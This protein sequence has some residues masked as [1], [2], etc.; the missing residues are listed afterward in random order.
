M[1]ENEE[2]Q[3]WFVLLNGKRYGPYTLPALVKG[4]EKGVIG[5]SAGVWRPGWDE[6]RTASDIEELFA[7]EPPPVEEFEEQ[8]ELEERAETPATSPEQLEEPQEEKQ[9]PEQAEPAEVAAED[10]GGSED[11]VPTELV[12]TD[13]ADA[14]ST[15]PLST[16]PEPDA[17]DL[18]LAEAKEANAE[19]DEA[20]ETDTG[21]PREVRESVRRNRFRDGP[22]LFGRGFARS[23]PV[24]L[25]PIKPDPPR[26]APPK[27]DRARPE[28]GKLDPP[29]LD[30]PKLDFGAT[31]RREATPDPGARDPGA[32]N[33]LSRAI[34]NELGAPDIG[35]R[36]PPLADA[37][38]RVRL[39]TMLAS[40]D[41]AA[42]R[43]ED[44]EELEAGPR[45]DPK[46]GEPEDPAKPTVA[47][48]RLSDVSSAARAR[49][50]DV[51]ADIVTAR[52]AA[53]FPAGVPPVLAPEPVPE[54]EGARRGGG[55]MAVILSVVATLIVV[56]AAALGA[57]ALGLMRVEFLPKQGGRGAAALQSLPVDSSAVRPHATL[58]GLPDIVANMPAVIALKMAD[59]EAY[60]RFV[61][62]F[63]G[64]YHDNEP[65][66]VILTQAR[67]AVRKSIKHMLANA[68][69]E[70]LL[71][72]TEVNLGYMRGLAQSNAGSC[73][74]L[75]DESKG[76]V[77]DA[78]LARDFPPLFE[79][80]MAVLERVI[81]NSGSKQT[82]PTEAE[83]RPYLEAV[84]ADLKNKPVQMQLLG[85]D[86]LTEAE[87]APYCDLVIA[88]YEGVRALP[89]ND[90]VKLLRNLY[91]A[92]A[93]DPDKS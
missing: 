58:D 89:F 20:K 74:A 5:R 13:S 31:T 1:P 33:L 62:R 21:S 41:V 18:E 32:R 42:P 69:N 64:V 25:E 19:A 70:S 82:A 46:K 87:Y 45:A 50:A 55:L 17:A 10:R 88:F 73:V 29:K 37:A 9:E 23:D 44:A 24:R 76:A 39:S 7:P 51:K 72:V 54:P 67:T 53:K 15:A 48:E 30:L 28:A 49:K 61:K 93:T 52:E 68:T 2:T 26:P 90:A 22:D 56:G 14:A 11:A 3:H 57:S 92:A 78:N 34:P 85:R 79:R 40:A 12:H 6:W 81:G 27:S 47:V 38:L 16:A 71:E 83:V 91:A 8:K 35:S 4:V 66:D 84:F 80:E 77:L 63:T 43:Q 75:S 86:K 36:S 65:D 60:G 59:S